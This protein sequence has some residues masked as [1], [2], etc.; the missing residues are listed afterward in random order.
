MNWAVWD[1][2]QTSLREHHIKP[3]VAVVRS[4]DPR[5]LG[6]LQV[7]ARGSRRWD[8][9][10]PFL[11]RGDVGVLTQLGLRRISDGFFSTPRPIVDTRGA[12]GPSNCGG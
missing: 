9:A 4:T 5:R 3:I 8:R 6:D 11:R 2:V 1:D 10:G 12:V 7:A